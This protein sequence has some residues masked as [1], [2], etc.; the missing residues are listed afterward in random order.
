MNLSRLSC[1]WAAPLSSLVDLIS[2][3]CRRATPP[4]SLLQQ[5]RALDDGALPDMPHRT[6]GSTIE[7][8]Y[9]RSLFEGLL[10]LFVGTQVD[11]ICSR[12]CARSS[13][14]NCPSTSSVVRELPLNSCKGNKIA[15]I[16]CIY[17]DPILGL[18]FVLPIFFVFYSESQ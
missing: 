2:T 11:Q 1:P 15:T 13:F 7:R 16:F 14:P 5:R 8:S 17:L 6:S 4:S 18:G 10:D 9:F 3:L 12:G